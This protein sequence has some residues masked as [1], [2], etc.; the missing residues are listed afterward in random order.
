MPLHPLVANVRLA[1]RRRGLLLSRLN[2][3]PPKPSVCMLECENSEV[4]GG[5][6]RPSESSL[7]RRSVFQTACV[8]RFLQ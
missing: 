8:T 4:W 6:A 1:A 5:G 2:R 7:V 3:V